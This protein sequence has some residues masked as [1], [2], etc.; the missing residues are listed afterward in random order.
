MPKFSF[1]IS[2]N[3]KDPKGNP[4]PF[5]RTLFNSKALATPQYA[6]WQRYIRKSFYDQVKVSGYPI[7]VDDSY[8]RDQQAA[9]AL[10]KTAN[11]AVKPFNLKSSFATVGILMHWTAANSNALYVASSI[12]D[13]LFADTSAVQIVRAEA[14]MAK[15]EGFIEVEISVEPN[16]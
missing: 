5:G 13:A 4:S 12:I 2:G 11:A 15:K 3:P 6:E 8:A 7:V 16:R 9:R 1:Q 14:D 10:M